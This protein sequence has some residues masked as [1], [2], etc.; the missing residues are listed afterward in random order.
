MNDNKFDLKQKHI[1][2]GQ[3]K[4]VKGNWAKDFNGEIY[5]GKKGHI[6]L[7]S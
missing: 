6:F 3:Q 2:F 1:T 5:A 4:T 7:T